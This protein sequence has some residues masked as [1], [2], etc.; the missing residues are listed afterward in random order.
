[1]GLVGVLVLCAGGAL[2]QAPA[3]P[4]DRAVM[5]RRVR[6]EMLHAWGGYE[7]WPARSSFLEV[8]AA[9]KIRD[10]LLDLLARH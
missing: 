5:A 7:T 3:P 8:E 4:L 1:M 10:S 2:A 9:P 6:D